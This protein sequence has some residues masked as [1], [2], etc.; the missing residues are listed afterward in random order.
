MFA[1]RKLSDDQLKLTNSSKISD[2]LTTLTID[3]LDE[4]SGGSI[5]TTFS[6][7][8]TTI[9]I[10]ANSRS[11]TVSVDTAGSNSSRCHR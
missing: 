2:G 9:S 1:A 6:Y 5:A 7:G 8:D 10:T 11:Y 4:V 3:E